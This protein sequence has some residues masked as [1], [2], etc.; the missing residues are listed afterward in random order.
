VTVPTIGPDAESGDAVD[1]FGAVVEDSTRT[2]ADFARIVPTASD[3]I[4]KLAVAGG[5]ATQS[6]ALLPSI[7]S[8]I[9]ASATT[10]AA[11]SSG[12][13][14]FSAIAGLFKGSGSGSTSTF[15]GAGIFHEGGIVGSPS[16][17]RYVASSMFQGAQRYHTGGLIGRKADGL[18]HGELPAILL[19]DEEVLKRSDPRHRHNLASGI[20]AAVQQAEK[21]SGSEVRDLF[22]RLGV[23]RNA[24]SE[25]LSVS[26]QGNR[27]IGG[28]VSAG[29]M[30]RVNER[31]PELLQ[32]AGRQYLM[33]GNQ[34]GKVEPTGGSAKSETNINQHFNF[35]TNGQPI[36]RRTVDQL[37]TAA[38]MGARR[39]TTRNS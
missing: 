26:V 30:Y 36:D 39:A 38:N 20:F 19:P 4:T 27:E 28:P 6:L 29:G 21:H 33:M 17:T 25:A 23:K 2:T 24:M 35:N 18:K 16:Q 1:A 5:S 11:A 3:V 9:S 7:I 8:L 14:I 12:G 15:G 37:A 31:G 13:G 10:N 22:A 34:A 32:V